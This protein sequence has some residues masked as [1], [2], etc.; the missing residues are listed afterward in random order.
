MLKQDPLLSKVAPIVIPQKLPQQN[1][2][3][4]HLSNLSVSKSQSTNQLPRF[5]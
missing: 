4:L 5:R 2:P 1:E 3:F